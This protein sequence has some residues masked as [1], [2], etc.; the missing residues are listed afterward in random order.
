MAGN[1]PISLVTGATGFVGANL[2]RRL[3]KEGHEV[4]VLI[5]SGKPNWRLENIKSALKIH[6]SDLS[7]KEILK[8]T[9]QEIQPTYVFHLAT[10]G[11]F[12]S[13]QDISS[14][15]STNIIGTVNLLSALEGCPSL[16]KLV[17]TGSSSEYGMK[18]KPMR[19]DDI[20]NPY[21]PYAVAKAAQSFFVSVA[22]YKKLVPAL[23]LRLFSV[24]GPYEESGRLIA[25]IMC[26][27]IS[28]K[29]LKLSAPNP[30]RDFIFIEDVVEAYLQAALSR[31]DNGEIINIGGGKD[32]SIQEA[33]ELAMGLSGSIVPIVWG[34][35]PA[36]SFE[37][38]RWIS[39][40][41]KAAEILEWKPKYDFR[42]G[43]AETK[44]WFE[45]NMHLY[46]KK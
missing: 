29:S 24:Y 35:V 31:C 1:K 23:T 2:T 27:L 41:S 34:S 17:N 46:A 33:A 9:I 8:H 3:I 38:T 12:P 25:D 39:D 19:E 15:I 45:A 13:Q 28:K 40:I 21:T 22:A 11:G 32:Y 10:Y 16:M 36:R 20:L 18:T 30:K 14:I 4:H 43:L 44:K 26:A 6:H 7:N 5:R 37:A 42:S